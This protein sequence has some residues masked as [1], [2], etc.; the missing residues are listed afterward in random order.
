MKCSWL[1]DLVALAAQSDNVVCLAFQISVLF[2]LCELLFKKLFNVQL[3]LY[4]SDQQQNANPSSALQFLILL[5]LFNTLRFVLAQVQQVKRN[6]S[7][8]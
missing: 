5:E 1:L 7:K 4:C 3:L 2:S 6:C 8:A